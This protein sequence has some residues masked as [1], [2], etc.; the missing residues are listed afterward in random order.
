[1]ST[2]THIYI[3]ARILTLTEQQ[4]E[5]AEPRVCC[6]TNYVGGHL[7]T[8]DNSLMRAGAECICPPG[9]PWPREATALPGATGSR[10]WAHKRDACPLWSFSRAEAAALWRER[11]LTIEVEQAHYFALLTNGV[12]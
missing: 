5:A 8:C 7:G 12:V 11:Q 9:W 6:G 1:M 3:S 4:W 10:R 2:T